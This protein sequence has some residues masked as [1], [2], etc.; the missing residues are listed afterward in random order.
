MKR[1]LRLALF[2]S[3][4]L[5]SLSVSILLSLALSHSHARTHSC[6]H[7]RTR[8]R[9]RVH[10]CTLAC[11]HAHTRLHMSTYRHCVTSYYHYKRVSLFVSL[12]Y[13]LEGKSY[14][15]EGKSSTAKSY[16]P[17]RALTMRIFR[18]R[19]ARLRFSVNGPCLIDNGFST[20]EMTVQV[21]LLVRL[22]V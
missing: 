11:M 12:L 3:L 7:A 17:A 4:S 10:I 16:S 21:T 20:D 18:A 2:L 13:H 19:N 9:T 15:L 8:M 5:L 1:N 14:N 6:T 22:S